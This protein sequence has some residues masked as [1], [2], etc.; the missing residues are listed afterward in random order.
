MIFD[1]KGKVVPS[2][3]PRVSKFGTYM[4]RN[5]V[6]YKEAIKNAF[7]ELK[8]NFTP[9]TGEI[10]IKITA[11]FSV[12]KS[13]SKKKRKSLLPIEGI[14]DSGAGYTHRPDADNIAKT[15]LDALNKVV[16]LDDGQVT[17]LLV[18]KEYGYEDKIIIEIQE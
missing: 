2:P 8:P 1:V 16:Y 13:Y 4:P 11:V 7:Q 14:E 9:L 17:G 10:N 3:R 18:L 5:Y 6:L 12:P 15:V